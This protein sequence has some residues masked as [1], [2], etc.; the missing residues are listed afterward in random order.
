MGTDAPL[1]DISEDK[2]VDFE[3]VVMTIPQFD[4]TNPSMI[5]QGPS[6]CMFNKENPQE[7]LASWLFVQY[8]LTNDVQIAYSETEGY[9]PVTSK[10]QESAEYQDYLSRSGEDTNTHYEVKI[11]AASLLLSHM[12]DT[13][14]TPVFNGS[15]SLRE[16][17]GQLIEDT[18]KSVRRKQTV[19]DAY[20]EKLYSD[21]AS[22]YRLDQLDSSGASGEK[23]DL[24]PLPTTSVVLLSVLFGTWI[25]ILTGVIVSK[26]RKY[27]NFK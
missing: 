4:T 3:T 23:R 2:L 9:V 14:I 13:F 8:L 1:S 7:V 20:M 24:G 25:L 26:I 21:T 17:A 6:I 16:A 15:T 22:L 18:V 19:D 10:A 27:R 5:S 11:S 12:D